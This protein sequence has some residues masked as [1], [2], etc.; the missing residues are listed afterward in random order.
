MR[1]GLAD[2]WTRHDATPNAKSSVCTCC[3]HWESDSRRG[4]TGIGCSY[5]SRRSWEQLAKTHNALD[6]S[7][8]TLLGLPRQMNC[9]DRVIQL[10]SSL[11]LKKVRTVVASSAQSELTRATVTSS[12]SLRY[13]KTAASNSRIPRIWE[14]M[15][16]NL[17]LCLLLCR[18]INGHRTHL[19]AGLKL[20]TN[21]DSGEM[22]GRQV[23][24][25]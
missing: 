4:F 17:S 10:S 13:C 14:P 19:Y 11:L 7:T 18:W 8:Q 20:A 24:W 12:A 21:D 1:F 9:D 22:K 3:A 6:M 23:E 5:Q 2:I 15:P 16:R 25:T